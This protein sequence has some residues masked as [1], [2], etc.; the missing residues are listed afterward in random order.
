L[1]VEFGRRLTDVARD[2]DTVARISGDEF[3][4]LIENLTHPAD[5]DITAERVMGAFREPFQ[6][7]QG[8]VSMTAT[9][10]MATSEDSDTVDDLMRHADMALYAAKAAG[11][12]RCQR[13]TPALGSSLRH[14]IEMRSAIEEAITAEQ[15]TLAYQP[16]VTMRTGAIAG[17]EALIRWPHPQRGMIMP[18]QFIDVAEETGLIVPLGAWV[19]DRAVADLA[20][21]RDQSDEAP[22]IS[23]N[24][25]ARQFR[26]AGF[27]TIVKNALESSGL[28]PSALLLE[29]TE[30]S[31][32]RRDGNIA[33]ELG[34]LKQ[35]GVHL[36]IDDFGTGYSSLSYLRE[37]PIDVVKIDRSF[38]DGIDR[39]SQR[40]ALIR[41][42]VAIAHTLRISV[43]A[44]GVE[45]DEQYA[46]LADIG[47]E[48]GQGY[49][50]AKPQNLTEATSLLLSG[51]SLSSRTRQ[52]LSRLP[53]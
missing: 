53:D 33:A 48:Y 41:G 43:I 23:V 32:L 31:L 44:E 7:S 2:S 27:V 38:V 16:I 37:M 25:A 8:E 35:L 5:A 11:K 13:Y 51:Q 19:L 17:F 4:L 3:A 40:L 36:A 22:Y 46:L 14:R 10:G 1:L 9:I 12:R 26:I 45:T 21:L 50:M 24:V 18:G 42:I 30:S 34:Q 49:L 15:F 47:C 52:R 6:L 39:S 28:P 20:R 29:L